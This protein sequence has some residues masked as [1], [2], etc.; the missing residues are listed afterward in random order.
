[1]VLAPLSVVAVSRAKV[2]V[3][4]SVVGLLGGAI[5]AALSA[6]FTISLSRL[7]SVAVVVFGTV[8]GAA[9]IA[10]SIVVP[11]AI[12]CA[13]PVVVTGMPL[14][15]VTPATLLFIAIEVAFSGK[16]LKQLE[17]NILFVDALQ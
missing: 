1:M 7:V 10:V 13:I 15:A 6:V 14:V 4:S 2:V 17:S 3:G 12:S 8:T 16:L 11:G 9:S 5:M